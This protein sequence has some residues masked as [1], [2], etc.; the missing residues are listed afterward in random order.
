ML[1]YSLAFVL[2]LLSAFHCIGMCGGIVGALSFGVAPEIRTQTPRLAL[3]ILAFNGGRI[4]SYVVA[5]LLLAWLG[6]W[7][8]D[9]HWARVAV[10]IGAALVVILIGLHVGEWFPR[11]T[12]IERLGLPLWRKLEPLS[13]RLHPV[14]GPGRALVYG[15]IW[16][17]VPCGLVYSV[18]IS[19]LSLHSV[20][21]SALYML[22]FGLGTLPVMMLTGLLAGRVQGYIRNPRVRSL[23][24]LLVI[25]M[26]IAALWYALQGA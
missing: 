13:R 26:G 5:G 15:I 1:A 17:W 23:A 9:A 7:L 12:S 19:S 22:L 18:L 14:R 25:G 4:L 10:Q 3:F 6:S 20:A 24:A 11:L 2:G 16:G 21:G 8:V